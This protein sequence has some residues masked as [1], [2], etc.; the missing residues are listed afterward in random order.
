MSDS[1]PPHRSSV[2]AEDIFLYF[3]AIFLP[4]IPVFI[5]TGFWTK[6]FRLNVLLTLMCG[7]PGSVHSI[8][9]VYIT[10]PITGHQ[11]RRVPH[12]DNER[13][14]ENNNPA[15]Q[16]PSQD[17]YNVPGPSSGFS[18]DQPPPYSTSDIR[19]ATNKE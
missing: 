19:E 8:Y 16:V 15:P 17:T 11:G 1:S 5:R 14:A 3:I 12:S 18:S 4:P 9:I 6:E 13:L 2:A 7:L 10:S